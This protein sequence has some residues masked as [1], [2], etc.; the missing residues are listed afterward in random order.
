M[1]GAEGNPLLPAERR[2][3]SF[4]DRKIVLGSTPLHE[5][6]SNVLRSYAASE[7]RVFEVPCPACGT[8][9]ELLW[10]HIEWPPGQPE[11]AAFRCPS[12]RAL[13]TESV[14]PGMVSAGRWRVT[15]PEIVGHVGFRY[16]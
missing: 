5:E 6:T 15:R 11:I 2:R 8:F 10:A 7:Q 9:A 16:S 12:C 3:L 14:K 1:P 4:P 13:V